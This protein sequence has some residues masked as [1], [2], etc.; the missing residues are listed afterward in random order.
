MN[1]FELADPEQARKRLMGQGLNIL[2]YISEM[3]NRGEFEEPNK[4]VGFC[5]LLMLVAEDKVKG[6]FNRDTCTTEWT[7]NENYLK[8]LEEVRDSILASK[9]IQGPWQE[10][11]DNYD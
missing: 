11:L 5:S 4:A 9:I 3:Y 6:S 1:H 10:T 2:R 8:K 7:L